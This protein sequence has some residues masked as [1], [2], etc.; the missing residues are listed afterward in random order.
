MET[1]CKIR[2]I[3]RAVSAFES[4]MEKVY[5]LCL[6]EGMLLCILSKAGK[7]SSGEIADTLGLTA[8]NASKVIKSVEQKSMIKR[9]VGNADKRHM[10]FS[11]TTKGR[12]ALS[13][14]NCD[15]IKLPDFLKYLLSKDIDKLDQ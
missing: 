15:H 8:S 9:V 11:L 1:L 5:N 10:Y 7:L 2:E 4:E 14:I 3:N 12:K 13:V 6:N